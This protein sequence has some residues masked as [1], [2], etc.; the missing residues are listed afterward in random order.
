ML[1]KLKTKFV[2]INMCLA[3]IVLLLAVSMVCYDTYKQD[4]QEIDKAL[5]MAISD[6][7][8]DRAIPLE[9]G[10]PEKGVTSP[11]PLEKGRMDYKP[12][13]YAAV[14]AYT[15]ENEKGKQD[16]SLIWNQNVS[17][18]EKTL[19]A[20]V[21]AA[22]VEEDKAG[23]LKRLDLFY[24]KTT[25]GDGERIAFVDSKYFDSITE[26]NLVR[27]ATLFAAGMVI[28]F[29]ISL[30][31]SRIA[32]APV[33]RAWKQQQQFVADASH[34]LKT[35]LTVILA[36]NDI[37]LLHENEK[38]ETQK[39]WIESTQE[40]AVHMKNLIDDLLFLARSDEGISDR[41]MIKTQVS[42]SDIVTDVYL[43][44]EPVIFDK[45]I[46]LDTDIRDGITIEGDKTQLRQLI[47][48]L[49]D[50][51]SKYAGVEGR[52]FLRLAK[53]SNKTKLTVINT[54][55]IVPAEDIEHIFERFYRSDKARTREGG[56]GLGLSIAKT[57]AENHGGKIT[58]EN[59]K[60]PDDNVPAVLMT[61]TL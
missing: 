42:I 60:T 36:N 59:G 7:L 32:V 26:Q 48:I 11:R 40:E 25:D 44:F 18:S 29:F 43:Q 20:A 4:M 54:G 45:G 16:I 35:P 28:L 55:T 1:K 52:I 47:H 39:K 24:M 31:L 57:I 15:E 3:G 49:L 38:L 10:R 14:V 9:I 12:F 21:D 5:E 34:E 37:L 33:K 61:V 27:A 8:E 19:E 2:L 23:K 51:A 30:L 6:T 53:N 17:M 41:R 46:S 56:Y 22:L 13:N 50:N 58:A